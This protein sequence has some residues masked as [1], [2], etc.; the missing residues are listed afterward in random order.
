M[1]IFIE[2]ISLSQL[3]KK[4]TTTTTY[5]KKSK[6]QWELYSDEG[7]FSVCNQDKN[8]EPGIYKWIITNE[9]QEKMND[10]KKELYLIVDH[11][12]MTY[13]KAYQIP[14][15]HVA[16][17]VQ[18]NTYALKPSSSVKF[19]VKLFVQED[20]LIPMDA[21]FEYEQQQQQQ[22]QV[23]EEINVFLESFVYTND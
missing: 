1:R 17:Q 16:V 6:Q 7:I 23:L 4:I 20:I 14:C 13:K 15:E 19:V 22:E 5:L 2:N 11:S 21:Y 8:N 12:H 18:F 3:T 10:L 9:K